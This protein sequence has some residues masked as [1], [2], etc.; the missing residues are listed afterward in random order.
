[1]YNLSN[2]MLTAKLNAQKNTNGIGANL[3]P[4][5]SVSVAFVDTSLYALVAAN[6]AKMLLKFD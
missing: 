2:D 1:M 4:A 6:V 5:F 3:Y